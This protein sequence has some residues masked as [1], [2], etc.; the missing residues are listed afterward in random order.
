MNN[1]RGLVHGMTNMPARTIAL[2]FLLSVATQAPATPNVPPGRF[3]DIG[4][5]SLYLNCVGTG[6]PTI[7]VETGLDEF[8]IDWSRVQPLVAARTRICTY[9]RAGY[10]FSDPGPMPRT[11][12][13]INLDLHRL[14]ATAGER[15]PYILVGH[16]FGGPVLRNYA[17]LYP[18]EVAGMALIESIHENHR[19]LIQGR[20]LRLRDSAT[21]R[22]IPPPA[23]AFEAPARAA[24]WGEAPAD[25]L[26]GIYASLPEQV[27]HWHAWAEQRTELAAARDSET[28]WSPQ[29]LQAMH[30]TSQEGS[31][32]DR[33]L[34][35]L[36]R[37]ESGYEELPAPLGEEMERE[38]VDNQ[39]A[40]SRLSSRGVQV[41][42]AGGHDIQLTAPEAAAAAILRVVG[43]VRS[44]RA[45][46]Q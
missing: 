41:I 44:D 6:A 15:G 42:A 22:A 40:L 27:R 18:D 23:N 7:V 38:R 10:G 39:R 37:A 11:Y 19:I 30:N 3:V 14:L 17:R 24:R 13:Q 8:A 46:P 21:G 34:V 32:G 5:W 9:D 43:M 16:S 20:P 4:G 12:D 36:T 33:P 31:L 35:V 1:R 25:S 45:S 26:D 28:N 29:Y 2:A